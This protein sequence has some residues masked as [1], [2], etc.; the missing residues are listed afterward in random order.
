[1]AELRRLKMKSRPFQTIVILNE[2]GD[3]YEKAE[4]LMRGVGIE[5]FFLQ[6]GVV[7][8]QKFLENTLISWKPRDNRMKTVG[9]CRPC[10]KKISEEVIQRKN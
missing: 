6:G 2:N 5:A 3:Q 10:G 8:Y 7:E 4:E 9:N 1:M